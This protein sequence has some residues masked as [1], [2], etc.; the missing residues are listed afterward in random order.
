MSDRKRRGRR[1][2]SLV[3]KRKGVENSEKNYDG[4]KGF[5]TTGII[6]KFEEDL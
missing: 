5:G 1:K 6:K 2:R 4:R 3:S